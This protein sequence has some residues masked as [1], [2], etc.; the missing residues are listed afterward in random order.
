MTLQTSEALKKHESDL[1]M[2]LFAKKK[3]HPTMELWKENTV[4][5]LYRCLLVLLYFAVLQFS[6]PGWG[7]VN[8]LLCSD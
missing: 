8:N 4:W 5:D 6:S 3:S 1:S 7:R 2:M